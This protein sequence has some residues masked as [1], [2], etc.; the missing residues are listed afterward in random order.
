MKKIATLLIAALCALQLSAQKKDI[1]FNSNGE[2]RI[3]QLTD[4]HLQIEKPQEHDKSLGRIDHI[5]KAEKP[6]FIAITG[7]VV[8]GNRE[9]RVQ[10]WDKVLAFL[11]SYRIPY[12]IAYGNHDAEGS[13]TRPEMSQ[14]IIKKGKYCVNTLNDKGELAD[15]R[16]P[17]KPSDRKSCADPLDIYMLDSHDYPHKQGYE[18]GKYGKYAWFKFDQICWFRQQCEAATAANGGVNVPSLVF[19]HIPLREFNEAY[20]NGA[21]GTKGESG[22]ESMINAGMFCAMLET[23]NTMGVFV[24]HD[25]DDTYITSHYGIAL[26]YG[27]FSGDDTTYNHLAHGL[28]VIVVKEGQRSFRTWIHEEDDR[29]EYPVEYT[30]GIISKIKL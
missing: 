11:D 22:G 10:M 7:D 8:T 24:G 14:N 15:I 30:D 4:L 28:R 19:F 16:I 17:V 29:I 27:G 20:A 6:D 3:L 5:I 9:T 25:H 2:L 21:I 26:G 18:E 23:G 13:M 12:A 1:S